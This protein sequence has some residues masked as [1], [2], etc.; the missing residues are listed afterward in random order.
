MTPEY[1]ATMGF[2]PVDQ[3]ALDYLRLIGRSDETVSM[4]EAYL[5]ANNMFVDCNE[6]WLCLCFFIMM[7]A[8]EFYV[9]QNMDKLAFMTAA[10]N[11]TSLLFRS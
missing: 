7:L 2:F 11:G 4:I 5:R 6:V 8:F 1:G 9:T 10:S 3:V